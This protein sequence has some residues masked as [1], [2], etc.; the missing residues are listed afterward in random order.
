MTLAGSFEHAFRF[1]CLNKCYFQLNKSNILQKFDLIMNISI[2]HRT[3][4]K[5]KTHRKFS[6]KITR[7]HVTPHT[8][9]HLQFPDALTSLHL[10][11]KLR[12]EDQFGKAAGRLNQLFAICLFLL[13][14]GL[15]AGF[16]SFPAVHSGVQVSKLVHEREA[17]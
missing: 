11:V 10:T 2:T 6:R 16:L 3:K 4:K 9:D 8:A 15:R 13:S 14:L 7:P 5:G 12:K 1:F 17:S